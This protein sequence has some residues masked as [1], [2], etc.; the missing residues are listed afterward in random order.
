[1]VHSQDLLL[2]I[3]PLVAKKEKLEQARYSSK[4]QD[5]VLAD[6]EKT[7]STLRYIHFN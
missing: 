2:E 7:V 6:L 5:K 1:M 3:K 4:H